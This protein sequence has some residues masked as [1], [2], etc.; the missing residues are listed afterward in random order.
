V[1]EGGVELQLKDYPLQKCSID[2]TQ[3]LKV[4]R[5]TIF[6]TLT[7]LLCAVL[8][9]PFLGYSG[10]SQSEGHRAVPGWEMLG[11]G[12]AFPTTLFGYP[13]VRKPPGMPWAIALVSWALG[14][15][16]FAA[17]LVSVLATAGGALLSA[18]AASRWFGERAALVAGAGYALMPVFWYPARSAEIEALHNSVTLAACLGVVAI[19]RHAA[20]GSTHSQSKIIDL[21]ISLCTGLAMAA[22][23]IAKGPAG[24]PVVVGVGLCAVVIMRRSHSVKSSAGGE[25]GALV[26]TA[27][28]ILF[29]LT[30][31]V[32]LCAVLTTGAAWRTMVTLE[33]LPPPIIEQPS[34][35][36]WNIRN[37]GMIL[38]LPLAAWVSGLPLSIAYIMFWR[39]PP[40]RSTFAD[41]TARSLAWGLL[42]AIVIYTMVGIGNDRYAMPA[43]TL[44]P[45]VVSAAYVRVA[46]G[47]GANFSK[48]RRWKKNL[49]TWGVALVVAAYVHHVYLDYRREV[50]TS[51]RPQGVHLAALIPDG[52]TVYAFELIDQRPE[53]CWYL[54]TTARTLGKS[55]DCKWIP[56]PAVLGGQ[57]PP[58]LPPAGNYVLM[59]TDNRPRDQYPPEQREY[60]RYNIMSKLQRVESGK[61]HNFEY[62]LYLVLP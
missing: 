30:P 44:C 8:F 1:G 57:G 36:L 22:M 58:T 16:E 54:E 12:E 38:S 40:L 15:T 53:V 50:R 51:G 33:G 11:R 32:M 28:R 31:G 21:V 29:G 49:R 46:S 37:L 55:I 26:T 5:S 17:R 3:I 52:A 7:V 4:S 18:W 59:R 6:C 20:R 60:E 10:L 13:Y 45:L 39:L 41:A 9:L 42:S 24:V 56:Y 43:L 14:Q 19:V 23:I 35:F 27:G 47:L 62:T 34:H 61:V 48:E 25:G 2:S